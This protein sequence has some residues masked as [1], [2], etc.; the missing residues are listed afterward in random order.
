[1][2]P[3][4]T[5]VSVVTT[6]P[7]AVTTFAADPKV[8]GQFIFA[9]PNTTSGLYGIY[10]NSSFSLTGA[11]QIVAPTYDAVYSLNVSPDGATLYFVSS[12]VG[13]TTKLRKVA[14]AGGTPV[15]L[16]DAETA[17]LN[18]AGDTL[19][20]EK[21][22]GTSV[23]IWKRGVADVAT[24]VRLTNR[25]NRN[26]FRPQW[27]KQGNRVIFLSQDSVNLTDVYSVN[28]EGSDLRQ[29]SNT[30]TF[31]E[32]AASYNDDS[33]KYVTMVSA[34]DVTQSGL[35]VASTSGLDASRTFIL[36]VP[37]GGAALYWTSNLG[38]S[39]SVP[40]STSYSKLHP[41]PASYRKTLTK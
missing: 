33:T 9:F 38:R 7:A 12:V 27:N 20:Y 34:L 10:S 17:S 23:N 14:K 32:L 4:G 3:D 22:N 25:T 11:V 8:T 1:V 31:D 16:D 29:L 15:V 5:G 39:G 30:A 13:D 24:P 36:A 2:N 18:F 35:Y 19:V 37:D 26:D 6:A 40:G 28:S 21:Y 41:L